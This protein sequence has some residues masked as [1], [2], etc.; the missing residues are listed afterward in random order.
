MQHPPPLHVIIMRYVVVDVM[1]WH[2]FRLKDSKDSPEGSDLFSLNM[3]SEHA[4]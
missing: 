3:Q 2:I 1:K 4:H